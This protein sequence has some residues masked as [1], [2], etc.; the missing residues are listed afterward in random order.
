MILE[1]SKPKLR[2]QKPI[3]PIYGNS[4]AGSGPLVQAEQKCL[5]LPE[6]SIERLS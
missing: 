3:Q 6:R 5:P 2:I 1:F 4:G